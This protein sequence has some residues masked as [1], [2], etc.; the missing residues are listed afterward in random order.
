MRADASVRAG[1]ALQENGCC[2]RQTTATGGGTYRAC[3]H[4]KALAS[5]SL[6]PQ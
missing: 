5:G 1:G 3:I 2:L 6:K 4:L